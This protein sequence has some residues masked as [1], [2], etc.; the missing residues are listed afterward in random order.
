MWLGRLLLD[1][2][3]ETEYPAE[4]TSCISYTSAYITY[5]SM[6]MAL[7]VLSLLITEI[8][9]IGL[10]IV[11]RLWPCQGLVLS[12][13]RRSHIVGVVTSRKLLFLATKAMCH[14]LSSSSNI[15][16]FHFICLLLKDACNFAFI[17]V[18][19]IIRYSRSTEPTDS[20]GNWSTWH[21][22]V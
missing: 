20:W 6:V 11:S 13:I 7:L 14:R 22:L 19:A 4:R 3:A 2:T 16:S 21:G 18:H 1:A 9:T 10:R 17:L 5:D 15:W 8:A 12:L